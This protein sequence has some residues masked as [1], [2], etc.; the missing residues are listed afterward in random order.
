MYRVAGLFG[1]PN[2]NTWSLAASEASRSMSVSTVVSSGTNAI[3]ARAAA[4]CWSIW[5]VCGFQRAASGNWNDSAAAT[6][7]I[8]AGPYLAIG[9]QTAF[10]VLRAKDAPPSKWSSLARMRVIASIAAKKTIGITVAL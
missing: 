7:I 3:A 9:V 4:T 8:I 1:V 6:A 5:K 10:C 2:Q